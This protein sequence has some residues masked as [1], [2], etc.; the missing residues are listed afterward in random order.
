MENENNVS[1]EEEVVKSGLGKK[2]ASILLLVFCSLIVVGVTLCSFLPKSFN[3]GLNDPS[4]IVVHTK[5][6]SSPAN[7]STFEKD[8]D[9][10]NELLKLY[11]ESFETTVFGA[12]FQGKAFE[13]VTEKEGYKSISSVSG[14]YLE[15]NY[16]ESQTIYVNGKTFD[17]F[18]AEREAR[19]GTKPIV[20][21]SSYISCVIEVKDSDTLTEINVYF[22]YKD[23]GTN[24]YSYIR[25]ATYAKQSALYEYIENL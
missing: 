22:K 7:G 11:K 2:I 6:S 13:G 19:D 3:P 25:L 10:Y 24:E 18:A 20:S 15:F 12:M 14:P 1:I 17:E 8:S 5:D 21:N 23:T 4:Y 9:G 16:T